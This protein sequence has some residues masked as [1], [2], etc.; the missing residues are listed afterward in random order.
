MI[1]SIREEDEELEKLKSEKIRAMCDNYRRQLDD[2]N[3]VEMDS[4]GSVGISWGEISKLV[5]RYRIAWMKSLKG[6]RIN[7]YGGVK[8]P[9]SDLMKFR[10]VAFSFSDAISEVEDE[11]RKDEVNKKNLNNLLSRGGEIIF[12][13]EDK[14]IYDDS[15]RVAYDGVLVKRKDVC[16]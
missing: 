6:W 15:G 11:I 13:D 4:F 2:G 8:E 9:Y 1:K 5:E 16:Y 10:V 3:A 14:V 7:L 12:E